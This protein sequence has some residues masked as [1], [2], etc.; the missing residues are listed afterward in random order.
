M[1]KHTFARL[2]AKTFIFDST[3]NNPPFSFITPFQ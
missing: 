2:K 3:D 1:K